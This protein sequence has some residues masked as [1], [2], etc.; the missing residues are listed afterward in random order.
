MARVR[1]MCAAAVA[2]LAGGGWFATPASAAAASQPLSAVLAAGTATVGS[3]SAVRMELQGARVAGSAPPP[4]VGTGAF[5][6]ANSR[7]V[8][9]LEVP[10]PGGATALHRTLF[11][12]TVVYV[13]PPSPRASSLPAGKNWIVATLNQTESTS[14]N[15]PQFVLQEEGLSPLLEIQQLVWARCRRRPSHLAASARTAR[16]GIRCGSTSAA[17]RAKQYAPMPP[18]R[19]PSKRRSTVWVEPRPR[20][21]APSSARRS[22]WLTGR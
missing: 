16:P 13:R 11:L 15:F 19:W 21:R 3:S 18:S 8:I 20:R 1:L 6:F 7:G 17:P 12:P 14:T 2:L 22:G 10:A 5:D 4:I 9:D